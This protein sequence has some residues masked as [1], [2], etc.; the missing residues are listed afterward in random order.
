[1]DT[2]AENSSVLV[3]DWMSSP[4]HVITPDTLVSDAYKTMLEYG[5]R[6]LPV[7]DQ[8]RLVGIVTLGD[9]REARPSPGTNPS[10]Y[11]LNYLLTRLTVAAVMTH[12]PYT[13]A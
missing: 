2:T 1:M 13:V 8:W 10:I 6:R 11:E 12:D 7:V 4:V 5:I 9:I 3:R